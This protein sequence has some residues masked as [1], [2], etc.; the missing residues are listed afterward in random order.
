MLTSSGQ[1]VVNTIG[2]MV[3]E[4][5]CWGLIWN[6]TINIIDVR[7]NTEILFNQFNLGKLEI[8]CLRVLG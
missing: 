4:P 8:L 6:N 1:E 7:K 2:E 3:A 5:N